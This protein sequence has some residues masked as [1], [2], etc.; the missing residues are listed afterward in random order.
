[1]I[2]IYE[3][4]EKLVQ[5][6][7]QHQLLRQEDVIYVRN[8]LLATLHLDHWEHPS[9]ITEDVP[10]PAPILNKIIEWAY[11]NGRLQTDTIAEREKLDAALMNCLIGRPSEIIHEFYQKY[12][13][14]PKEATDWF[15][16]LSKASNYIRTEDIA[17]NRV[18]KA[19]TKYG[20]MDITINLSK[21]EKDPKEIAKLKE[22]PPSSYPTCLLCVENEGFAGTLR[23]PARANHRIIP[24]TLLDEPWCFQYSP[25]MYY[26][27]HC[28]VFSRDHTPM[29]MTKKTFARLLAF[30]EQFPHYFIGSNADLPIVGGSILSHDHFQGGR[31]TFAIERAPITETFSLSA[32]PSATIGIVHWPMSVIRIRGTKEEVLEITDL[33]YRTWQTYCDPSVHIYASTN[34]VPHNTVT[35]I[36][37]RRGEL[38]EMDVVLRNNKTSEE[39][40]YGIFHPHEELHHIKKENIGLI[41]VMGLAVLP[42]RLAAELDTLAHYLV[43][44]TEKAQWD[45]ALLKHWDW[46]NEL[47]E[48]YETIT[49]ENVFDLLRHE[50]GKRFEAVLEH[51][52]VFKQTPEGQQAFRTFMKKVQENITNLKQKQTI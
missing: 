50:V 16:A 1:M 27:E 21:P 49:S 48:K 28:I 39:H 22:L 34:G 10:S 13:R 23:H 5:Y 47:I 25:Y 35:P 8:R 24:L 36:A 37:R 43:Q 15:Y 33:I 7:L 14:H 3:Q 18:W 29:K 42:G 45:E 19:A 46:Y 11:E 44:K 20:E 40:P 52:G 9:V 51:A 38:F 6:G 12:N 32:Y 17:K 2:N 31:Y 4:I 41:E 30:I 26:N